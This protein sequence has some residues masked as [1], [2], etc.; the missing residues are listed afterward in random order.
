MYRLLT[1]CFGVLCLIGPTHAVFAQVSNG[2]KS[3]IKYECSLFDRNGARVAVASAS[4]SDTVWTAT[5]GRD[6]LSDILTFKLT[7]N[8]GY[9]LE[10]TV[11]S[12]RDQIMFDAQT[13]DLSGPAA[14]EIHFKND[15]HSIRV[16]CL[17][18]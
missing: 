10:Y 16:S 15:V 3:E 13:F 4:S 17:L 5:S 8:Q 11:F 2:V 9:R 14:N 6:S 1:Q 7:L 18:K 12:N